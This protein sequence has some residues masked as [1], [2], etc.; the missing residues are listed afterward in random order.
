MSDAAAPT[1][2]DE[3][4]VIDPGNAIYFDAYDEEE[5]YELKQENDELVEFISSMAIT[6]YGV[7]QKHPDEHSGYC[8]CEAHVMLRK[9]EDIARR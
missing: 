6:L 7:L 3:A 8:L 4:P 1:P 9:A 5:F 2:V